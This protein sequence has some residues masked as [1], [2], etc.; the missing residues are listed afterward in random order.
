MINV[1]ANPNTITV[2]SNIPVCNGG[3][4]NLSASPSVGFTYNWT[5][6]NGFVSASPQPQISPVTLAASGE[7]TLVA[8]VPGCPNA[9]IRTPYLRVTPS[10]ITA[11]VNSPICQGQTLRLSVYYKR[12]F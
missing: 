1:V 7:Y 4:L 6:P 12:S 9:V 2:S 8:S 10:G 3:S 5:G 11:G